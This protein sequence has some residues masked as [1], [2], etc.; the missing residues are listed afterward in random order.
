MFVIAFVVLTAGGSGEADF[1]ARLVS[2]RHTTGPVT[3]V[4]ADGTITVGGQAARAG[5]WYSVR[6]AG[7][8][9]PA[10][11]TGPQVELTT[12][13]RLAG[14]VVAADGDAVRV[15]VAMPGVGEQTLRF[16]L[17]AVRAVWVSGR[18]AGEDPPWLAGPRKRDVI[19]SRTGD[20]VEGSLV[21]MDAARNVVRYQ[22]DGKERQTEF[23]RVQV[24]G[25]NTDLARVRRP[26]GPYYRLTLVDGSRMS[27][28]AVRFDGTVWD[29]QTVFK[30]SLKVP[31][32]QVISVDV[33]QGRVVYLSDWKPASYQY[34]SYDGE[35][36]GWAADRAVTDSPLRLKVPAGE[37][38]FD[39]GIGLHAA[40][41]IKYALGGKFARFEAL[42]GLD[43]GTARGHAEVAVL[44]DGKEEGLPRAGR[45]TPAAEALPLSVDVTG[46][47]ELSIVIRRGNGGGVQDRVN[48]AE[49]RLV[50]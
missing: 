26:K 17:S 19:Q 38:T 2:G 50:P 18:P 15:A 41:T 36:F 13:D 47:K 30:E 42:A 9:L 34:E 45:L 21:G 4:T 24:V 10:W 35:H 16:P 3:T 6:R 32:G 46:A 40:C 44:V 23:A 27:V 37:S 22:A 49:A 28:T 29:V 11:P 12:G 8:A 1:D 43:A 5:D 33:E 14:R 48:L 20:R 31:A 7:A 25:F 39:R